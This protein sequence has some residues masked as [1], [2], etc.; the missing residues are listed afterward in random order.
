MA[1]RPI[2]ASRK[3]IGGG[4]GPCHSGDSR[5][6]EEKGREKALLKPER[7]EGPECPPVKPWGIR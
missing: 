3:P 2:L 7:P 1:P 4:A 6:G 5:H